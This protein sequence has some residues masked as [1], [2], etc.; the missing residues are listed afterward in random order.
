MLSEPVEP[1]LP[2]TPACQIAISLI[3]HTNA[4]KT[5]LARTLLQR[6]IGEVRDAPHVTELAE[7]HLL[8]SSA[9][10]DELRLW[11]T[12][13]F[14][15]TVRLVQRL[16][17]EGT[18]VGWFLSH[19]WD[20]WRDRPF[21]ANQQALRHVR[22]RSD[23]VLYLVNA[24]ESP[25]A[26][27]YVEPEMQLL[28][29]MGKPVIVLLNQL[30]AMRSVEEET[31]DVD[32]WARHLTQHAHVRAVLPMDAFARCWVQ[33]STLLLAIA[34][35]LPPEQQAATHRLLQS[36]SAQ[37]MATLDAAVRSLARTLSRIAA[38][39]IPVEGT[40]GLADAALS[41]SQR[42]GRW[43][44]A[45][46]KADAA[47]DRAQGRLLA[48]LDEEVRNGTAELIQLHGLSGQAQS[49]VLQRV[50]DLV[51]TAPRVDEGRAAVWGGM[52]TGALTGLKAD[53]A[54]GGLTLGGGLLAG[55][56]LGALGAAGIARGVNVLRGG[57]PSWVGWSTA[58][59]TPL[60]QAALLRYLAVAHFGRGRGQWEQGEAPP[61]WRELTASALAARQGALDAIWAHRSN[62]L[63]TDGE[64]ERLE[65]LLAPLLQDLVLGLLRSLYPDARLHRG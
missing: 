30:G 43:L 15:D 54:S 44:G 11:D 7:D 21:W 31:R 19:V 20:R 32:R 16:R 48:L 29:W 47:A 9:H 10:G 6:D 50:A 60:V 4:G 5:T 46:G 57:G 17:R 22:E 36:W 55:G 40:P 28:L 62:S 23:V 56:L 34:Q 24:A 37:R 26:A 64:A 49:E 8:L 41:W 2:I 65:A 42:V 27:S 1:S 39:R 51:Q 33:E 13:G 59:M 58:A 52:V 63:Q 38:S 61:H 25:E 14:G 18:A 3:S 53:I 45:E 35:V 12:P